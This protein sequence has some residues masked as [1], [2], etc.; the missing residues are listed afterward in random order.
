MG[1]VGG[2]LPTHK[3]V[4][5]LVPGEY[6]LKDGENELKVS[7]KAKRQQCR[8]CRTYTFQRGSYVVDVNTRSSIVATPL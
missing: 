8:G 7:L 3:T 4:F 5:E 6:R 1:F 2:T